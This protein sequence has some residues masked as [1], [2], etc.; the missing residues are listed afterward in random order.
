MTARLETPTRSPDRWTFAGALATTVGVAAA[1]TPGTLT[2]AYGLPP[3]SAP[4]AWRL[5]G[6]RTALIG[7]GVLRGDRSARAVVLPVQLLDQ[8]VFAHALLTGA[9]PRRTGLAAMATSAVLIVL[10]LRPQEPS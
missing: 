4:L 10:T 9:V 6:I 2:R 5:F 8:A 3:E 1:L 7:A